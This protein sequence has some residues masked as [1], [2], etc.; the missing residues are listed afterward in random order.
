MKKQ[1]FYGQGR[2]TEEEKRALAVVRIFGVVEFG[3]RGTVEFDLPCQSTGPDNYRHDGDERQANEAASAP[4]EAGAIE[5]EEANHQGSD[6]GTST[7]QRPVQC[8]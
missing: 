6:N 1:E 8:S 3:T 5:N 2:R 4:S 7:L